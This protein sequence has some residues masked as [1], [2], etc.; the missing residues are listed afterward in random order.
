[1]TLQLH[2]LSESSIEIA[3][4]DTSWDIW[5]KKYRLKT[6][7]GENIDVSIDDTYKRVAKALADVESDDRSECT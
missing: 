3:L 1:M 5:D 2:T 6:K 4:Q 7:N